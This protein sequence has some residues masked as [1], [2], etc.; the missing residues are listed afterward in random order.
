MADIFDG[1]KKAAFGDIEFPYVSIGIKGSL[2]H[3]V[4]EYLHRPGAEI[5]SLGRRAYE[6]RFG[7]QFHTDMP[8][9]PD[10][11][12]SRLSEL[13]SLCE[14]EQTFDLYV[15]NLGREVKAKAIEW[16]RNLLATVRSGESVEL[17]FLE[18]ASE[19]YTAANLIG[20]V[21]NS[22][23][24]QIAA[25]QFEVEKLAEPE[26]TDLLDDLIAELDKWL[27]VK[28]DV[29]LAIEYQ[30]ARVDGVFTRCQRLAEA[31]AMQ[32]TLA[33][34]ALQATLALW[35][36]I[37]RVK[38][39]SLAAARPLAA[40]ITDDDHMSVTDVAMKLFNGSPA[41]TVEILKLND[42]DDALD[43]RVGTRVRYLTPAA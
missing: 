34:P 28:E 40:W 37:A 31:P 39:D 42:F 19:R 27:S 1:F 22:A 35:A 30:H 17:V 10:L 7:C 36:N 33:T 14:S 4:H 13:V 38:N 11:Y 26:L 12:P 41:N 25:V 21:A 15:P 3:H 6:F 24:A 32:T 2:R 5:E 16:P 20:T 8:S 9:W 23:P 29:E 43:I 18:D